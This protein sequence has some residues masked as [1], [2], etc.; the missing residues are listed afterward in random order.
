MKDDTLP[1]CEMRFSIFS[2]TTGAGDAKVKVTDAKSAK[3]AKMKSA[4]RDM[5]SED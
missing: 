5:D 3:A 2:M 1:V 4:K